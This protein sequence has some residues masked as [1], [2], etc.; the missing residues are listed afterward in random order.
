MVASELLVF[1]FRRLASVGFRPLGFALV[2]KMVFQR[3]LLDTPSLVS[4]Q[5]IGEKPAC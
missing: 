2:P 5:H 3:M 1:H 4:N